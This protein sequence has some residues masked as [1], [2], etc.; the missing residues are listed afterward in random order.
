MTA[1][2]TDAVLAAL[3]GV[4]DPDL[5]QNIVALGFITRC[6]VTPEGA[7]SVVIN[8]TTPACPVKDEMREQARGLIAALDGVTSVDVEM[9][10]EVRRPDGPAR[11]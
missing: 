7:V 4:I 8:L 10:A 3:E 5:G 2:T 9:T 6:E 11:E 1:P